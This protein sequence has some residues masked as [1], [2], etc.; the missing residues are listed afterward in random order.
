M[1][2]M[3]VHLARLLRRGLLRSALGGGVRGRR[4]GVPGTVVP[5]VA[6]AVVVPP[7]VAC[8][9]V[10]SDCRSA[11]NCWK[12]L[13]RPVEFVADVLEVAAAASEGTALAP[14]AC[15]AHH[16]VVAPIALIDIACCLLPRSSAGMRLPTRR[17]GAMV[18]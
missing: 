16:G 12:K 15:A 2:M 4:G 14:E 9:C 17:I 11:A 18:P 1:V 8:T 7:V 6:V 13:P 3:V 5:G 10:S